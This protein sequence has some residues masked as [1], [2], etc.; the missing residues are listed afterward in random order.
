[1]T[2]KKYHSKNLKKSHERSCIAKHLHFQQIDST[3]TWA[4]RHTDQWAPQGV[5]LIT[6]SEQ[7]A[8]RGR[9]KRRWESPPNV[10]IYATFCFWFESN[11]PEE[12][13]YIPQLLALAAAQTLETLGFFPQIKWPNDV[14]LN[15]KKIAGI[16]CETLVEDQKRGIVCG[17]G[18]NVNMSSEELKRIDRPATSLL[19]EGSKPFDVIIVLNRLQQFFF[20]FLTDFIQQGF[21]PFFPLLQ[22]RSALKKGQKVQFCDHQKHF[23]AYFDSW[24]H[25]GSIQLRL[26]DG[27]LKIFHAGEFIPFT[28][29][30]S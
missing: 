11:R 4:K 25:D 23:E 28:E 29:K 7:T 15:E 10:N 21:A 17:I 5:T 12:I 18:L 22:A 1:M 6:A 8:G 9:F 26:N 30:S 14:L 3:N 20:S 27:T 2:E 16:L 13:G 19:E 24:N